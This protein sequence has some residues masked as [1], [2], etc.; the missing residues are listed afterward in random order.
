MARAG[1]ARGGA[2]PG[3]DGPGAAPRAQRRP[4]DPGAREEAG[5]DD[6]VPQRLWDVSSNYFLRFSVQFDTIFDS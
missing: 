3:A 4:S 1:A 2:L 6:A 5:R